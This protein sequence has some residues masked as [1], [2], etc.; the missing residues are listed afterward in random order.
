VLADRHALV[1]MSLSERQA[2]FRPER[3]VAI[4]AAKRGLEVA[5]SRAGAEDIRSKG[6]RDLVPA[7]DMAVEDAVRSVLSA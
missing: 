2:E 3:V 1:G 5:L 6:G 7:T 4:E